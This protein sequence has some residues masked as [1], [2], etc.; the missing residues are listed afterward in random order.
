LPEVDEMNSRERDATEDEPSGASGRSLSHIEKA[1]GLILLLAMVVGCVVILSPF[2]VPILWAAILVASTWPLYCR[3][4]RL[5]NGRRG[6]AALLMTLAWTLLLLLPLFE[7]GA[8]LTEN[9]FR[10]AEAVRSMTTSGLPPPPPWL[11]KLPLAGS[12]LA[13][14]W[15]SA[16]SDPEAFLA[17]VREQVPTVRDW[18][19]ARGGDIAQ[20][21]LQLSLSLLTSFF[22][23]RD[24]PAIV[25]VADSIVTRISGQPTRRFSGTAAATITSIVYGLLGAALA[26]GILLAVGCWVAGVPGPLLLG[27]VAVFLSL[28][29]AGLALIWLPAA[30][31]LGA[32]GNTEWAIF[33][34][35]WGL[36][37]GSLEN[38]LRPYLIGHGSDLPFLLVLLGVIGGAVSF[39]L[40]GIFLGPALLGIGYSLVREWASEPAAALPPPAR[41]IAP[42]LSSAAEAQIGIERRSSS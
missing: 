30:L 9:V 12:W 22:F 3:A 15:L 42:E 23:Y 32:Q 13:S 39:G 31:W 11:A 16:S 4:E 20:G 19:L 14:K 35:I 40:I 24:G 26:Q 10:I 5:T 36:V 38:F 41:T 33:L 1:F 2:F 18:L 27:F 28:I 17:I 21:L 8:R 34:A 37:V 29:P 25:Q 7:V 6:L